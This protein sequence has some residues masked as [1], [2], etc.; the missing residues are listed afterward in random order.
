MGTARGYLPD[1]IDTASGEKQRGS[2]RPSG[3]PG[4]SHCL[5]LIQSRP[6]AGRAAVAPGRKGSDSP[7]VQRRTAPANGALTAV[8]PPARAYPASRRV[9]IVEDNADGRE[10]LCL[11]LQLLGHEVAVAA[12]GAEGVRRALEFRPEVALVDLGLPVLNGFE[13]AR[14]VRAALGGEVYLVAPTAYDGAEVVRRAAEAG[15]DLHVAKPAAPEVLMR[16]LD[17]R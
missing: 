3:L 9:L 17:R 10:S 11:L 2:G 4:Y 15:F 14:R 16:V 6:T 12:D 8:S 1:G 7:A 5:R 13:V